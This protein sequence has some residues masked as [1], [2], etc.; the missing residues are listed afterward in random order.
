M[1]TFARLGLFVSALIMSS[2]SQTPTYPEAQ[3][4]AVQDTFFGTIVAD[5]Y[6]WMENPADSSTMAWVD[7]QNVLTRSV[8]D[9]SGKRES[10]HSRLTGLWNYPKFSA[11]SKKGSRYFFFKNDGL[12]NQSV[13][14]WQ[15]GPGGEPQVLLDPNKLS[16][17][18]TV[19]LSLTSLS[20]GGAYLAYGLSSGGSDR[21]EVKIRR[22]ATGEDLEDV[23]KWCK[24]TSIAWLPDNSGFFYNRYPEPG[25]VAKEDENMYSRV[26]FH[27]L[28][29]P[30]SEDQLVFEQPE[31]KTRGFSPIITEDGNYLILYVWEGTDPR[32]RL[33]IR[34]LRNNKPFIKL[35]DK[36]DASYSPVH[37]SGTLLYVMT[38]LD[39]PRYRLVAIDLTKPDPSQWKTIIPEQ[40]EVL[41]N[42]T[43]VNNQ[44]IA[45]YMKD[46]RHQIRVFSTEGT[47]IGEIGLP[48]PGTISLSAS[49]STDREMFITLTSF[50]YPSTIFR[51]DFIA[52]AMTV[53]RQPDIRFDLAAYETKQVFYPSKD[54]TKIPMFIVYKKGLDLNGQNPVLLYGYGGFNVSL[55]PSFSIGRL[56]WLEAGGVYALANLRGGGEYG[57]D[58]HQAGMLGKKQNVFD[59]LHAAAEYL[60]AEKYTSPSLLAINGGSNGGLLVAAAMTQRPDLY[61]AVVCQVP[62]I[63]MLRYHR[64][65]VGHYWI[66]EYG[67]AENSKEEF[68]F[69]MA[70]S[71]LHNI[72]PDVN[73]P[74]TLITTA[75]TDDRVVPAHAKKF[76]ATLQHT[77]K[78]K[79]PILIRVETRAGHGAGKPTS[80]VIDETVDIYTFLFDRFGMTSPAVAE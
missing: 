35:L 27:K 4:G 18:G 79:N 36:K 48:V 10:I 7:A 68:D 21:Q 46:A 67:N 78:G 9:G 3:R 76:A 34:D 24:F 44:F 65:S 20:E 80:K 40:T 31:F 73:Y 60:I 22:V 47:G 8:L 62:V 12:Q 70:Y 66:P 55:T 38:N 16:E 57:E 14:Y 54:G 26:Y 41:D 43:V 74:A 33:Y 63:D 49:R 52:G 23:I 29:T 11:P 6:R 53:F 75:D 59:D 64:L 5:P 50:T 69:M 37:S 28:G 71:P 15:N 77:Y 45:T 25:T 72:R 39:A 58:W 51:Y 19:S 1:S 17:D 42:I 61:G 56:V 30:Q 13:L 32:N 2:C